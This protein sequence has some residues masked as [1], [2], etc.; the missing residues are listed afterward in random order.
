MTRSSQG[1]EPPSDPERF[2]V[3]QDPGLGPHHQPPLP[4]VQM[5]EQHS[6]PDNELTAELIGDAHITTTSR[7]TG[8][9]TLILCEPL[10]SRPE[11]RQGR[12][13]GAG[14]ERESTKINVGADPFEGGR[15]SGP[16][17]TPQ[18]NSPGK[19]YNCALRNARNVR[20]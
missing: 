15:G 18:V 5:R 7:I 4:L 13:S 8:S 6:E 1:I 14:P 17:R 19:N 20:N 12:T 10:A 2:T 3:P 16:E 9:N 11:V